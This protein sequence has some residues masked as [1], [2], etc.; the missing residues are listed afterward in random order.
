M[1]S[2]TFLQ[3]GT[4][5]AAALLAATVAAG[6]QSA[7]TKKN[8][9]KPSAKNAWAVT[10]GGGG[11]LICQM[12]Q[13]VMIQKTKQRLVS[14]VIRPSKDDKNH[15][16]I[17]AAPHG[18]NIPEGVDVQIDKEKARKFPIKTSDQNG[19]YMSEPIS[20]ALLAAMR[21]GTKLNISYTFANGKKITIPL[22]LVG[23]S[24]AYKKLTPG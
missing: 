16:L 24:A 18:L 14:V 9:Q 23:F 8:D 20:D 10:C 13:N 4:I 19:T 12:V 5:A 2:K 1:I 7:T 22:G 17:I 6:A 15:R 3:S 21:K 11:E